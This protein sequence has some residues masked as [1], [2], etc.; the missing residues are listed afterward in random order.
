MDI[1]FSRIARLTRRLGVT[2]SSSLKQFQT[3]IAL[4]LSN[5][6]YLYAYFGAG[7]TPNS[8]LLT[9]RQV[10]LDPRELAFCHCGVCTHATAYVSWA[11]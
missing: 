7:S 3:Q 10:H 11:L 8:T 9:C 6:L 2:M 4:E 1:A 5:E